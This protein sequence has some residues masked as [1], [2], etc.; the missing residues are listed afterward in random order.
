MSSCLFLVHSKINNTRQLCLS[1]TQT[2]ILLRGRRLQNKQT[3]SGVRVLSIC[4]RSWTIFFTVTTHFYKGWQ[5]NGL[6]FS[7]LGGYC[8]LIFLRLFKQVDI[9]DIIRQSTKQKATSQFIKALILLVVWELKRRLW[10]LMQDRMSF[11]LN[12]LRSSYTN[13]LNMMNFSGALFFI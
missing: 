9:S 4:K 5:P 10:L 12:W 8:Y 6:L 11:N 13:I 1:S 7:N 2:V 3:I